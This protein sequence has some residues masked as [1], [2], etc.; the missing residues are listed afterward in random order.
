MK[1]EVH[2]L[3]NLFLS[4]SSNIENLCTRG[5]GGERKMSIADHLSVDTNDLFSS[6]SDSDGESKDKVRKERQFSFLQS[7]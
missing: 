2:S 6:E 3:S 4:P 5:R 1:E 7:N